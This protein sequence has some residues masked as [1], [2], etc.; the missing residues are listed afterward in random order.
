MSKLDKLFSNE[1]LERMH[2]NIDEE[3]DYGKRCRVRY[4]N[5]VVYVTDGKNKFE[6]SGFKSAFEAKTWIAFGD[7][8]ES[9]NNDGFIIMRIPKKQLVWKYLK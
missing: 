4:S 3:Y 1:Y 7:F 2:S 9:D 5:L 6:I 8:E